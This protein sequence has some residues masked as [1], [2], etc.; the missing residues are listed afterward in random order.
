MLKHGAI[1]HAEAGRARAE[2][3][4]IRGAGMKGPKTGGIQGCNTFLGQGRDGRRLDFTQA[5]R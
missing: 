2:I 4:A 1:V 3:E 5:D